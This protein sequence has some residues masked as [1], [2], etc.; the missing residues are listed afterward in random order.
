MDLK[1]CD[2]SNG[3]TGVE[4]TIL[5]LDNKPTDIKIKVL[6]FHGK[7]GREVFMNAVK[8]NKGAKQS[9]LEVM[10]GLTVGWSGI[11]ENGKELKFS[12]NEAKRIYETYPLIANQV[13]RFAE[14][15]RNFLKK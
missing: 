3:E 11:S 9:T 2:I 8:E 5:D 1:N 6:S 12:H 13:E 7:K 14:N 10:V 4:L 15:A